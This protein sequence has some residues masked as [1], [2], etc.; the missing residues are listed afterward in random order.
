MRSG[1]L[2][3]MMGNHAV[4]GSVDSGKSTLVAVLTH[5]AD[6]EPLLDDGRGK[7]RTSIF[8]HKHEVQTGHTSSISQSMLG[9]DADGTVLNY[10]GINRLTAA[11]ISAAAGKMLHFVDLCGHARFLKTALYGASFCCEGSSALPVLGV[12]LNSLHGFVAGTYL[13]LQQFFGS[14]LCRHPA[15]AATSA[16]EVAAGSHIA[17]LLFVG[18]H[19][20]PAV[21]IHS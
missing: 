11:E 4:G 1:A 5:G 9:Y 19:P 18:F 2:T 20:H 14:D 3:S 21:L 17:S 10:S 12:P 15:S 13:A 6:G 8:R 7:A 16:A